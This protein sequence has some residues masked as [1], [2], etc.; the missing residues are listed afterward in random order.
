MAA[1]DRATDRVRSACPPGSTPGRDAV[2]RPARTAGPGGYAS[3][4]LV[5]DPDA[6]DGGRRPPSQLLDGAVADLSL[7]S[8][9][10][11]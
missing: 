6:V 9:T 10:T 2:A 11:S 7:A 1:F 5:G 8:A 3:A 4:T